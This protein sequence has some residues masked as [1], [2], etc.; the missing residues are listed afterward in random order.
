M[1]RVVRRSDAQKLHALRVRGEAFCGFWE[2]RGDSEGTLNAHA[3]RAHPDACRRCVSLMG[4][5]LPVDP[6]DPDEKAAA[7]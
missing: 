7:A 2:Q 3:F 6:A 1:M 4:L 5:A